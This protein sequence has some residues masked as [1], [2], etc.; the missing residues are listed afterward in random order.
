MEK[1]IK[2]LLASFI[3]MLALIATILI[4][5]V[6]SSLVSLDLIPKEYIDFFVGLI[7]G[8]I[9]TDIIIL[10]ILPLLLSKIIFQSVS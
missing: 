9:Y 5:Y 6:I 4:L 1:S 3:M 2:F 10:L 7:P 8:P